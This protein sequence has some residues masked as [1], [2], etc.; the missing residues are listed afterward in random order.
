M[1]HTL[2]PHRG[3]PATHDVRDNGIDL[4]AALARGAIAGLVAGWAFLLTEMWFGYSQGQPATAPL[5]AFSTVFYAAP[6]PTLTAAS[7]LV[8][9]IT[10]IAL[11]LGF[12]MGF[13]LLLLIVPALRRPGPLVLASI[14][15]GLALWILDFQ[16]LG[17]TVFPFFTSPNGPNQLFQGL[18]HPLIFGP[19]LVPFFLGWSHRTTRQEPVG[20]RHL[21]GA[22]TP[23]P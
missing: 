8:G 10:H 6:A 21:D 5:A 19:A 20:T 17:R 13:A 3:A 9:V 15:Y 7:L 2:I 14:G 18:I 12:G 11:S 23:G 16:I 22:T 1:L 4:G